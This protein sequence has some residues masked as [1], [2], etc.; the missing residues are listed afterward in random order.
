MIV[1]KN[2]RIL[3]FTLLM[4]ALLVFSAM[5]AYSFTE[6]YLGADSTESAESGTAVESPDGT[7]VDATIDADNL[8]NLKEVA[9]E[10]G[11]TLTDD[12]KKETKVAIKMTSDT[13]ATQLLAI[14]TQFTSIE[15]LN[16]TQVALTDTTL[17]LKNL[18]NMKSGAS[19]SV[20]G[21]AVETLELNS[22]MGSLNASKTKL[23]TLN[24]SE[25]AS[26]TVVNLTSVTT[27]TSLEGLSSLTK[28]VTLSL[29]G[30]S[31]LK[32]DLD[33]ASN[34]ALENLD[35]TGATSVTK[36]NLASN[37]AAKILE[38][39]NLSGAGENITLP[40]D[41]ANLKTLNIS[42][43]Q[44]FF[45]NAKK[46]YSA[47]STFTGGSQSPKRTSVKASGAVFSFGKFSFSGTG[48]DAV[49]YSNITGVT[50][51]DSDGSTLTGTVDADD[52]SSFAWNKTATA[53]KSISYTYATMKTAS[54][55]ETAADESMNV[56]VT[57][58]GEAEDNNSVGGS[59]GGCSAGFGALAL[60]AVAAF[61]LKKSR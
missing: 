60:A 17:S 8:D 18:S 40:G 56:T 22:N 59:G 24:L 47:L 4:S 11:A 30:A 51:T 21:L 43:N 55:A 54:E 52:K 53:I 14:L 12:Q 57:L 13:T 41:N 50:A 58:S 10:P 2:K 15:T 36:V 25:A 34:T 39:S 49:D 33:F 37:T 1:L 35:L 28:L 20:A 31:A 29:N 38:L 6:F 3:V 19:V 5:P 45:L 46:K 16:L 42:G 7:A 9:V 32:Q 48:N 44:F 23:K 27:L 26:M 61:L